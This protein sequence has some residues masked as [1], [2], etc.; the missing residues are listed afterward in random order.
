MTTV[1]FLPP[2]PS[3]CREHQRWGEGVTVQACWLSSGLSWGPG[4][5][6]AVGCQRQVPLLPSSPLLLQGGAGSPGPALLLASNQF[7]LL[8]GPTAAPCPTATTAAATA[9]ATTIHRSHWVKRSCW[10]TGSWTVSAHCAPRLTLG[11]TLH[12]QVQGTLDSNSKHDPSLACFHLPPPPALAL[13][14]PSGRDI[15]PS[16]PGPPLS[17]PRRSLLKPQFLTWAFLM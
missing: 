1:C 16:D 10:V 2:G 13:A 14:G 8:W 11:S 5:G 12:Q 3:A 7:F 9:A 17:S 4:A 6:P 15:L